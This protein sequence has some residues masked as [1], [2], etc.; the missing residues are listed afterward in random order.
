MFP[1]A[2]VPR[3]RLRCCLPDSGALDLSV[4]YVNFLLVE[5]GSWLLSLNMRL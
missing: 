4:P 3:D 2:Q 5:S 1:R